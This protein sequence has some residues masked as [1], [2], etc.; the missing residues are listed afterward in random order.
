MTLRQGNTLFV[1]WAVSVMAFALCVA[2]LLGGR[3]V[4]AVCLS[5]GPSTLFLAASAVRHDC[6]PGSVLAN[7]TCE[8]DIV[9]TC[10]VPPHDNECR[11]PLE[12]FA[13]LQLDGIRDCSPPTVKLP[14][15]GRAMAAAMLVEEAREAFAAWKAGAE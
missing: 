4:S 6:V 13:G 11:T 14:P 15:D 7:A 8:F 12:C 10:N 5:H 1:C 2:A 9:R 3:S